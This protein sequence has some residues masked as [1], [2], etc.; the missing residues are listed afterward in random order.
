MQY[1]I[2]GI[3]A[4]VGLIFLIVYNLK[5]EANRKKR[6]SESAALA[7]QQIQEASAEPPARAEAVPVQPEPSAAPPARAVPERAR[8]DSAAVDPELPEPPRAQRGSSRGDHD[9]RQA[10][11]SFENNE[12]PSEDKEENGAKSSSDNQF[13]D[14]LRSLNKSDR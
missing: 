6:E 8:E 11:R 9:Y 4:V 5:V 10:L 12:V 7:P 3:I 2:F 14:A 1:I 13:R